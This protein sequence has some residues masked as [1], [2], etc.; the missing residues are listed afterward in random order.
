MDATWLRKHPTAFLLIYLSV[1]HLLV[2]LTQFVGITNDS[3]WQLPTLG[4]IAQ[5]IPAYFPPGYPLL[6]GLGY[7]ISGAKAGLVIALIQHVMMIATILWCFWLLERCVGAL[8]AC[9][10]ILVLGLAAPTLFTP[11]AILSENVALFG[12]AGTLYFAVRYRDR[13]KAWAMS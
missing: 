6:V 3:F 9:G 5:G 2:W 10:T 11:Q 8:I 7:L 12:M 4:Q 1:L 13:G